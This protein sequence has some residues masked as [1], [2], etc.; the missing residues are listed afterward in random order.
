MDRQI[1]VKA[2]AAGV[3]QQ[4]AVT[5]NIPWT[6]VPSADWIVLDKESGEGDGTFTVTIAPKETPSSRTGSVSIYYGMSKK[7]EI[8][9]LQEG[10]TVEITVSDESFNATSDASSKT[11]TV[12]SNYAW[13]ATSN[14]AWVT[15]SPSEGEAAATP[16]DLLINWTEAS[17]ADRDAVVTVK[18]GNVT[19]TIAV[20][21]DKAAAKPIV[22]DVVFSNGTKSNQPFTTNLVS[23][24]ASSYSL[25]PKQYTLKETTYQFEIYSAYIGHLINTANGCL[26]LAWDDEVY[27]KDL[28][29][30]P[31]AYIKFPAI[32]DYKL[33]KVTIAT[34]STA[35]NPASTKYPAYITPTYGN[36]NE[37][38]IAA[39]I[40][41]TDDLG[42]TGLANP[43]V[44]TTTN[45]A[46]NTAYYLFLTPQTGKT[47]GYQTMILEFHLE[48]QPE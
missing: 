8:G 43:N 20:H 34:S 45:P 47:T 30:E 5:A 13:T 40:A 38:A 28:R 27:E 6:L 41:S 24:V 33:A 35:P 29:K 23:S 9:V 31:F 32:P 2:S 14:A 12:T 39:A 22:L 26:L 48:Y 11:V 7:S 16:Q 36:S 42:R 44:L 10:F 46:A 4:I 19:R 18:S 37:E 15:V 17:G 25:G 1:P 3:A 21:Q